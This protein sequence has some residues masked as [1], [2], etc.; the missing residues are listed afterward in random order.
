MLNAELDSP[1]SILSAVFACLDEAGIRYCVLHGYENFDK[2]ITSDIDCFV[3]PRCPLPKLIHSVEQADIQLVQ[4]IQHE[5]TCHYFVFYSW[6]SKVFLK[7]DVSTDY[8]R[9]GTVFYSAEDILSQRRRYKTLWIPAVQHEFG[10]YLVKKIAKESLEPNHASRLSDL[11]KLNPI[12][13]RQEM[14]KFWSDAHTH[15]L[16]TAAESGDWCTVR[17]QISQL[18]SLLLRG[19]EPSSLWHSLSYGLA[20]VRRRIR[21]ILQPTGLF[22][23][24]LGPDGAGKSSV[25]E[26]LSRDLAPAFRRTSVM[27]FSPRLLKHRSDITPVTYPHAVEPRSQITSLLKMCYWIIDFSLGYVML[28][29]PALTRS[30]LV[31]FDRY[32]NDVLVDPKRYRFRGPHWLVKLLIRLV[33]KPDLVIVLDAPPEVLQQ[34]KQEVS[35]T[36]TKRQR[37][38]YR[39]LAGK[40]PNSRI[41]SATF[42]LDY[43]VADVEQ[44]ALNRMADRVRCRLRWS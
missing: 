6:V 43:V 2:S 9:N 12:A 10:Y 32:L 24:L 36:E 37:E 40:M 29:R 22:L 4:H 23:V 1:S 18:R 33:P 14:S 19:S 39:A 31:I 34:R 26:H 35:F 3:D 28:I 16:S 15:L 13:C 42:P 44:V 8:R 5:S 7:L 21:R 30:T 25:I 17:Q 27:H 38:A 20:D 11:Y 41:I